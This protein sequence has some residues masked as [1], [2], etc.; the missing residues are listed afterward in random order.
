MKC[1][2]RQIAAD[3][4][5]QKAAKTNEWSWLF[6]S[7]YTDAKPTKPAKPTLSPQA[8]AEHMIELRFR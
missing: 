2:V 4:M 6:V 7:V 3:A 5:H 1:T 8:M